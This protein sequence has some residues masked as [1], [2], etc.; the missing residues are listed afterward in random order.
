[1]VKGSHHSEE[2]RQK[3]GNSQLGRVQSNETRRK[4]SKAAKDRWSSSIERARASLSHEGSRNHRWNP[5]RNRSNEKQMF[6]ERMRREF[7]RAKGCILTNALDIPLLKLGYTARE[8]KEHIE[9]MFLNRM[10]WRNWGKV[11]HI[12]HIRPVSRWPLTSSYAEVHSLSNL[13]PLLVAEN[14]SKGSKWS[15]S[16]GGN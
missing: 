13:Q 1:M 11:W 2:T 7:G 10:S 8:L 12:D 3:I 15:Y 14:L 9:K 16:N 5:D 6:M 4:Q